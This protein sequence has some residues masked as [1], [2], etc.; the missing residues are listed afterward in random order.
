MCDWSDENIIK[1]GH[2]EIDSLAYVRTTENF[3]KLIALQW[4]MIMNS[5]AVCRQIE[6]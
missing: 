1:S 2:S 4:L 6:K 5:E 3:W